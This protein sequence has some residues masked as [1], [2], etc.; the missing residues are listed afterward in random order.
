MK[1]VLHVKEAVVQKQILMFLNRQSDVF[2]WKNPTR[3]VWD[4]KRKL[5]RTT[6]GLRGGSD[7]FFLLWPIGLFGAI[8]CKST[9]VPRKGTAEQ[10]WF[11]EKVR[12][13]G[14][15]AGFARSVDEAWEILEEGR[16]ISYKLLN[17]VE[18][19]DDER[20]PMGSVGGD[21]DNGDSASVEDRVTEG[22]DR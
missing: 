22:D 19:G 5:F 12:E 10:Q 18:G 2:A 9:R 13:M 3:G 11:I 6:E 17:T 14:G 16:K 1:N 20:S 8:E 15:V 4:Q 21:V 7:I